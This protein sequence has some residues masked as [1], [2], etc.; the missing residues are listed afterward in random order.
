MK[1]R[2]DASTVFTPG[3]IIALEKPVL[4]VVLI[5]ETVV[6][7]HD[8]MAYL[9]YRPA[10]N[11]VAYGVGGE[12]LWVAE[13]PTELPVDA[14]MNVNSETPL[15]VGNFAGFNCTISLST[16]KIENHVFTK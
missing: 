11:L 2:F 16:G 4:E 8:Y 5:N 1:L 9:Q 3:G 10:N 7:I 13:N 6:V 14:Y 15:I 12:A